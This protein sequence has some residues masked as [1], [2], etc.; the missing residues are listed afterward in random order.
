MI[1]EDKDKFVPM[2]IGYKIIDFL[3]INFPMIIDI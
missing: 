1:G 3:E 2:H